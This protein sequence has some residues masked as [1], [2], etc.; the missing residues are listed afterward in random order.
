[1]FDSARTDLIP[2]IQTWC[3]ASRPGGIAGA[4]LKGRTSFFV[5]LRLAAG[6][7][8]PSALQAALDG[9]EISLAFQPT[10]RPKGQCDSASSPNESRADLNRSASAS[11]AACCGVLQLCRRR[12]SEYASRLIRN[13][14]E[15]KSFALVLLGSLDEF[16][17]AGDF[18]ARTGA[19]QTVELLFR[20]MVL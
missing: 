1:M 3:Q 18:G 12:F 10:K 2:A 20:Q 9:H 17:Q 5:F 19:G 6:K 4:A 13:N 16:N 15:G 7:S 14:S 8:K 11:P